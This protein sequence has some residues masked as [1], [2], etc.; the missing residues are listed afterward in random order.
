MATKLIRPVRREMLASS[1]IGKYRNR[2]IVVTI[3]GGD[4]LEFQIKGTRQRYEVS[5]HAAYRLAQISTWDSEY[6]SKLDEYNRKRKAG[7]KC[8]R[9][10]RMNFPIDRAIIQSLK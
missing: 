6:Q 9:P 1:T 2:P 5:L 10:K 7:M 3:K 4:I 8:R